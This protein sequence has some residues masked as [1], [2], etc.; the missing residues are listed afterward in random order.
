[1]G[2]CQKLR[3]KDRDPLSYFYPS[4]SDNHPNNMEPGIIPI[5]DAAN[6]KPYWAVVKEICLYIT[7]TA[8]DIAFKS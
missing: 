7:V 8:N 1:M 3:R 6:N 5:N 2:L 4:L